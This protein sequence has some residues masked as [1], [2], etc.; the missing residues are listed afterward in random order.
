MNTEQLLV[1]ALSVVST[2]T[3]GLALRRD[4]TA[5]VVARRRW[6]AVIAFNVLGLPL[7]AGGLHLAFGLGPVG[8]GLL[9]AAATPG[10]S[11]GPLLAMAAGGNARTAG[12]LL[13]VTTVAGAI[14]ALAVV[15]LAMGASTSGFAVAAVWVVGGSLVPLLAGWVTQTFAP[16]WSVRARTPLSR[17]GLVLLAITVAALAWTHLPSVQLQD[18]GWAAVVVVASFTPAAF[19]RPG[20]QR[21]S[22]AQV[23]AVRNLTIAL[24]ALSAANA[25]PRAVMAVLGYGL[26]MYVATGLV[27]LYGRAQGKSS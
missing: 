5:P 6:A 12:Q 23:S 3:V 14:G 15:S 19:V 10:G 4:G 25:E 18:L 24:L 17:L 11:T 21:L 20:P 26:L 2:F 1:T 22:V 8:L 27:A 16:G 13:L 7:I 9:V